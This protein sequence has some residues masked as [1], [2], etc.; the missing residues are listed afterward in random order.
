M[1]NVEE[2]CKNMCDAYV[3]NCEQKNIGAVAQLSVINLAQVSHLNQIFDAMSRE[4]VA[5]TY[6]LSDMGAMIRLLE[7]AQRS[8]DSNIVDLASLAF[9]TE[10]LV[11]ET[12]ADVRNALTE[13]I[14]YNA[15]GSMRSQSAG[16]GVYYPKNGEVPKT[17]LKSTISDKYKQ[18][19]KNVVLQFDAVDEYITTGARDL[20]AYDEYNSRQLEPETV[21]EED[22]YSMTLV[23]D[24]S[25]L[26]NVL[27]KKYKADD[28][29]YY[30]CGETAE[31][32]C[33]WEAQNYKAYMWADVPLLRGEVVDVRLVSRNAEYSIYASEVLFNGDTEQMY[34]GYS[35]ESGKYFFVGIWNG[36]S[37]EKCGFGDTLTLL[38][39]NK[40]TGQ[41][42][43]SKTFNLINGIKIDTATPPEGDYSIEFEV[44][45][46]YGEKEL[47]AP[48]EYS[49]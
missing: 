25:L 11:G 46:V 20:P 9:A 8:V 30:S 13:V 21:V 5:K 45:D 23:G 18:F 42:H 19:I 32:E 22:K 2:V 34:V 12:C 27:V 49:R 1:A 31:V 3:R 10:Q 43:A 7:V 17:Y 28:G 35:N 15:K 16:L 36:S 44:E 14:L 40:A 6:N 48:A 38:K 26:K 41:Q 24:M 29:A 33:N 4:M 37:F 47:S 39:T